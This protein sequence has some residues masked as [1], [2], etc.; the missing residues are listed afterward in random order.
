MDEN[1]YKSPVSHSSAVEREPQHGAY[2]G[3]DDEDDG[4][5][6]ARLWDALTRRNVAALSV[7]LTIVWLAWHLLSR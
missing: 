7:L 6:F 3:Y 1:P 4:I 5:Y 2:I